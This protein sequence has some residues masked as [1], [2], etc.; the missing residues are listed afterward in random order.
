MQQQQHDTCA[1]VKLNSFHVAA[2]KICIIGSL[3]NPHLH[4]VDYA[5][6]EIKNFAEE[7]LAAEGPADADVVVKVPIIAKKPP[8]KLTRSMSTRFSFTRSVSREIYE[9]QNSR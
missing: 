5:W 1:R 7:T 4:L 2:A 3:T 6:E 8:K 9:R